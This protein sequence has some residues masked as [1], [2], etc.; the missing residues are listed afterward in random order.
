MNFVG[1]RSGG[2]TS[3]VGVAVPESGYAGD[4]AVDVLV[5]EERM[6]ERIAMPNVPI[7]SSAKSRPLHNV[8]FGLNAQIGMQRL[9]RR[10]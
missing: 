1:V 8:C 7:L 6:P 3:V 2:A 5:I 10:G 4:G 9:E